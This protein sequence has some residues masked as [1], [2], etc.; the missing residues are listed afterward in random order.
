MMSSFLCSR[1]IKEFLAVLFGQYIH[2]YFHALMIDGIMLSLRPGVCV[3]IQNVHMQL[4]ILSHL[5]AVGKGK[6]QDLSGDMCR[7]DSV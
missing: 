2:A 6:A 5:Q 7:G 1:S 4:L 3:C